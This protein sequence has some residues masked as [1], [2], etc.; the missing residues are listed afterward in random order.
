MLIILYD[1][2]LIFLLALAV[3]FWAVS[4]CGVLCGP[5]IL[6]RKHVKGFLSFIGY[7][8]LL[9]T[10]HQWHPQRSISSHLRR[11]CRTGA[12]DH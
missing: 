8:L 6:A 2:G 10:G 9:A 12:P 1:L 5:S 4:C 11:P 3:A 7:F